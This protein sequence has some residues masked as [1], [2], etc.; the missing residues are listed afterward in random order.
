[1]RYVLSV[2][3]IFMFS[4]LSAAPAVA[5]S[6]TPAI[7]KVSSFL[8]SG[9]SGATFKRTPQKEFGIGDTVFYITTVAWEPIDSSAGRHKLIWRWYSHG[10]VVSETKLT[11]RFK[12]T[13]FELW[14][15]LPASSLGTGDH[16][17]ELVMDGQIYDSQNFKISAQP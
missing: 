10:T 8:T 16:R 13:P 3:L 17:V 12:P 1:M 11:A 6:S 15:K 7:T 9:G 2:V 5:D 14:G 4:I